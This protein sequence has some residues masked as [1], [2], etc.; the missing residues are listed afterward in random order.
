MNTQLI[1]NKLDQAMITVGT[2]APAV[3]SNSSGSEKYIKL[4]SMAKL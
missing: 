1:K 2:L 3:A 4:R